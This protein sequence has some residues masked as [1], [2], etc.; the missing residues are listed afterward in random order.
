MGKMNKKHL[1]KNAHKTLH[2]LKNLSKGKISFSTETVKQKI[3]T[4]DSK[5]LSA[6]LMRDLFGSILYILQRKV[7]MAQVLKYPLTPV[8]LYLSHVDG[9]MLCTPKSA[10]LTYLGTKGAM[11][12]SDEIDF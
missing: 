12:T 4:S 11:T 2:G 5:V 1:L 7:D 8:S 3:T 10:L 6:C 9:T